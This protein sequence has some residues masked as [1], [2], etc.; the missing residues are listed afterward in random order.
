MKVNIGVFAH[1][2]RD[3]ERVQSGDFDRPPTTP[4]HDFVAGGL[5]L[6][7]LAEPLGF[8]GIWAPEHQ[9]TPYGMTPNPTADADL[10]RGTH[11]AGE[12]RHD[13]RRRALVASGPAG[14]PDRLSRY[15]LE[16]PLHDDRARPRRCEDG[17]RRR[18]RAARGEPPA[19]RRN[20]RH[21][22]AGL[23]PGAVLLRR[24]DLQDSGDVASP[25]PR[26]RDLFSRI[27]G[28]SATRESL[29]LLARRGM[30]P[31]FVGN[32]PIEEAGK[33]VQLVNTIRQEEGLPP[34]QPK[35]VLFMYCTPTTDEAEGRRGSSQA[36]VDVNL[37]YG[38][39][40]ASNFT[41][42]K[43]YEAYATRAA[44]ATA[45]L[46]AAVTA[47]DQSSKPKTPGYHPSNLMIGTPEEVIKR[48][49]AAQKACSFSE[50]TIV[51][52][53]GHMPYDEAHESTRAVRQG[54]SAGH[55]QDGC[56]APRRCASLVATPDCGIGHEVQADADTGR[57]DL[58]ALREKYRRERDKR[59]RPEGSRQYVEAA[60]DFADFYETDPYSPPVV[61]DPISED[62]DVVILGGGFAGLI[63]AAGRLKG[64]GVTDLRI[65]ELAGDFGGTWYWNRYP[66]Y[67]VRHRLLLLPA[68]ARRGELRPEGTYSTTP[69]RA[70][71]G[72]G[73]GDFPAGRDGVAE[74][75][76]LSRRLRAEDLRCGSMLRRAPFIITTKPRMIL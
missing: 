71:V 66:G 6:G 26:S 72:C 56:A 76:R 22:E 49:I 4:D 10:F 54:G 25:Q 73:A 51:P 61:R 40:D 50:I 18:R 39:A 65:I 67:A 64:A 52:Q 58:P 2:S 59:L 34:C 12:P 20:A 16:G 37:H 29:E 62:I 14:A 47:N 13:G 74:R 3:W 27:Y 21:P 43:G 42:V 28:S 46:A 15:R 11:G 45:V 31:L 35:N 41:G 32:K 36:N 19:L 9:G 48:I 30:V 23:L 75:A 44:G 1:N 57:L 55:P 8:D 70:Q 63:S 38:F 33:E 53:F 60:D 24:R 5:A 69:K 7:D 68:A 17:V